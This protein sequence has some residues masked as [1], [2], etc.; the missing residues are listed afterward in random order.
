MEALSSV[1]MTMVTLSADCYCGT[2][3]IR[4]SFFAKG[5]SFF[6]KVLSFLYEIA[7]HHTPNWTAVYG[8]TSDRIW[9]VPNLALSVLSLTESYRSSWLASDCNRCLCEADT[10]T[11]QHC[12]YPGISALVPLWGKCR[13]GND[14][15]V[16]S[17]VYHL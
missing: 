2:L 1:K 5:L 13:D 9:I 17:D 14:N 8:C 4:Q 15:F 11:R 3:S 10:D 6:A 12:L 7:R 16:G